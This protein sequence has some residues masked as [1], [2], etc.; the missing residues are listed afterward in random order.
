M[1]YLRKRHLTSDF[2]K[3]TKHVYLVTNIY[4]FK[5]VNEPKMKV[6]MKMTGNRTYAL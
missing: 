3:Y 5:C 2:R 6:E 4:V 1:E